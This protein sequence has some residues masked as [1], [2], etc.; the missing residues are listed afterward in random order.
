MQNVGK[1]DLRHFFE[2]LAFNHL[3]IMESCVKK[4]MLYHHSQQLRDI[5]RHIYFSIGIVKILIIQLVSSIFLNEES[6]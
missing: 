5:W 4:A 1:V 3:C 6:S 2:T